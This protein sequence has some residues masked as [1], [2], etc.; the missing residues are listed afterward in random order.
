MKN[1][2]R[3]LFLTGAVGGGGMSP[4]RAKHGCSDAAIYKG[5]HHGETQEFVLLLLQSN[6]ASLDYVRRKNVS[7]APKKMNDFLI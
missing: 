7:M 2:G 3:S 4:N 6:Q 5:E 1:V